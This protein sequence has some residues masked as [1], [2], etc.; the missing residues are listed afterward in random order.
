MSYEKFEALKAKKGLGLNRVDS[1]HR[2]I[3]RYINGN[4]TGVSTIYLHRYLSFYCFLH[5]WAIDHNGELPVTM[6]AAEAIFQEL[7]FADCACLSRKDIAGAELMS[8]KKVLT[9]Y[10]T[11]LAKM[12]DELREQANRRGLTI[13][14]GDTLVRFNKWD[15]F[16]TAPKTQ[17]LAIAREY[18][19]KNRSKMS[20][21]RL[22][23]EIYNLPARNAIFQRLILSDSKHSKYID[24]VVELL[25]KEARIAAEEEEKRRMIVQ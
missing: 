23:R 20:G 12:T 25:D 4:L 11:M 7:L 1:T 10:V 21:E 15:Y 5:N 8:L 16:R 19:I 17:L 3:K 22:A 14:D 18:G 2:Q 6:K 9:R 13:N 24:D